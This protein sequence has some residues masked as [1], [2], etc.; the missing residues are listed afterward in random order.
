M[1]RMALLGRLG[2]LLTLASAGCHKPTAGPS[3]PS[4]TTNVSSAPGSG[5]REAIAQAI[6]QHLNDNKGI[7][8]AAMDMALT[9]MSVQG[10]QAQANAEFR[11]KQGGA[12]MQM[13]YFLQRHP[14]G[15]IVTRSQPGGG[16]LAH[17]PMDQSHT[18]AASGSSPMPMPDMTGFLKNTS[19][20]GT[21]GG[22]SQK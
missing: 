4:T 2:L 17:P 14:G 1:K 21:N 11:L 3:T 5:D 8:M 6:Q 15:W 12:S 13:T 20:S 22:P 18:G 10:D 7:N 9:D 19:P 16:Q